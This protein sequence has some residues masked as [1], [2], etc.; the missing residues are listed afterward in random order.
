VSGIEP[1]TCRLQGLR[2]LLVVAAYYRSRPTFEFLPCRSV[3]LDSHQFWHVYGTSLGRRF[4]IGAM[5]R[6]V[7][8]LLTAVGAALSAIVG[9]AHGDLVWVMIANASA[10]T[11]L[12]TYLA[13]PPSKKKSEMSVRFGYNAN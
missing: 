6:S 12:A 13:L 5:P 10:A 1:L 4:T 11:G 3:P 9:L 2:K 7:V 8:G